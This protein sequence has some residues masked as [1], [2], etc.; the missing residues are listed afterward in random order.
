ME[1]SKENL[2]TTNYLVGFHSFVKDHNYPQYK[3]NLI[4]EFSETLNE[5]LNVFPPLGRETIIKSSNPNK[6]NLEI[7]VTS[8]TLLFQDTTSLEDVVNNALKLLDAWKKHSPLVNLRLVGI[9]LDFKI[10]IE[11]IK[12]KNELFLTKNFIKNKDWDKISYGDFTL[13]FNEI[14][15]GNDYNIQLTFIEN[16]EKEYMLNG[17]IDFNQIA[18]DKEHSHKDEDIKRIIERGEMY[19]ETEYINFINNVK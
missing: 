19:F 16:R 5:T 17:T 4:N 10:N 8:N 12:E 1:I 9:V 13:R 2:E 14:L 18:K 11:P 6:Q 3:G 15:E 7:R